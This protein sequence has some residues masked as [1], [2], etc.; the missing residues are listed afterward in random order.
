MYPE[1]AYLQPSPRGNREDGGRPRPCDRVPRVSSRI[2]VYKFVYK[3][4][5]IIIHK[6]IY[7]IIY[8]SG[9]PVCMPAGA[10]VS[11]KKSGFPVCMPAGAFFSFKKYGFHVCMPAGAFF[12]SVC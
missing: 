2:D 11:F 8:N 10:F 4:I 3:I 9:F 1:T 6:S 7:K 5:Y 12:S